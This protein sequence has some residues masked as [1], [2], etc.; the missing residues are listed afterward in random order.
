M[1]LLV[2]YCYY[3][4]YSYYYS[5]YYFIYIYIY[6][7]VGWLVVWT[8]LFYFPPSVGWWFPMTILF[9]GACPETSS[10]QRIRPVPDGFSQRFFINIKRDKQWFCKENWIHND[11]LKGSHE[12]ILLLCNIGQLP[13]I[14]QSTFE[15]WTFLQSFANSLLPRECQVIYC[16]VFKPVLRTL[17]YVCRNLFD[18]WV[19]SC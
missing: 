1:L 17:S 12:S 13:H 4:Y 18:P 7:S 2:F 5:Y 3:S 8:C 10:H 14:L 11:L 9:F 16:T 19:F 15:K 6:I